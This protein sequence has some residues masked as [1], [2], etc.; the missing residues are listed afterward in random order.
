MTIFLLGLVFTE[1]GQA[2][3]LVSAEGDKYLILQ[4]RQSSIHSID[5]WRSWIKEA[6]GLCSK[7]P[8]IYTDSVQ[9]ISSQMRRIKL[10]SKFSVNIPLIDVYGAGGLAIALLSSAINAG[11]VQ[12]VEESILERL[13]KDLT[14]LGWSSERGMIMAAGLQAITL[15]LCQEEYRLQT[16]GQR[17]SLPPSGG[18]GADLPNI[19]SR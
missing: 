10:D 2:T 12:T 5:E 17:K 19:F 16:Q 13:R 3:C 7:P 15:S 11:R 4:Y 1:S 9:F 8:M 18:M 6:L 14:N